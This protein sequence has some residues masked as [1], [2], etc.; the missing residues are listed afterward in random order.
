MLTVAL[1]TCG[2]QLEVALAGGPLAAT[3]LVR[4]AGRTP[5]SALLL[6]AVDLLLEDAGLEPGALRRVVVTRGPGSFTGI[7]AGLASAAGLSLAT[8]AEA[9]AYDSLSALAARSLAE[10]VVW[11]AQPGRRGEVYA[12]AFAVSP[13]APPRP[14]GEIEVM[15]VAEAALKGPWLAAEALDLGAAKRA[16]ATAST[17]EGLL[18]LVAGGAP[19]QPLEPLYVEGPPIHLREGPGA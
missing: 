9:V 15:A 8:G 11:A 7:R 6:A 1:V 13:P 18:R 14:L 3:S 16:P 19:S 12:R 17:A 10:G 2:P 5:R 4:L